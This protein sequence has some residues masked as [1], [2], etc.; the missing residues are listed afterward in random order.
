MD[1]LKILNSP[2]FTQW[3]AESLAA[4]FLVGGFVAVAVG[5]GLF[6]NSEGTFKLFRGA[7]RWISMRRA[8]KPL[9]IPRDT[10]PLVLRYRRLLAAVFII[11]GAFALYGL[12][13]QYD[14][15]AV[16]FG[17]RLDFLKPS[18][19]TWA[20]DSARWVLIVGNLVAI[21]IGFALAFSPAFVEKLE[22]AGAHWYSE[23]QATRGADDLRLGLDARVVSYPRYSGLIMA[24]FGVVL[25]GTFGI[26]LFG[27]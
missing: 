11:G 8:T 15:R 23:R 6:F 10:R 24:F 9:E 14:A 12:A 18:F 17:L 13:A 16:I 19:A 25:I 7:N 2:A 27:R 21:G 4:I 22:A 3:I 20:I 5:L 1:L 26:M